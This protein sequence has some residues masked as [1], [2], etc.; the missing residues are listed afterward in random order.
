MSQ[1]I[2]LT[3]DTIDLTADEVIDLTTTETNERVTSILLTYPQVKNQFSRNGIT[4]NE[5]GTVSYINDGQ[6]CR[7]GSVKDFFLIHSLQLD[8]QP[9]CIVVSEEKHQDGNEHIHCFVQWIGARNYPTNYFDY[10]G[11]H[12]N[13]VCLNHAMKGLNYCRKYDKNY[14][15]WVKVFELDSDEEGFFSQVPPPYSE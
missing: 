1:V 7:C 11:V 13:I 14:L 5:D 8:P 10:Q 9:V 2:D 3:Q 12:P 15:R 6:L 4:V